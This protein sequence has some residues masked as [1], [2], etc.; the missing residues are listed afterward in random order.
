MHTYSLQFNCLF[1][2]F[3]NDH[4]NKTIY[5]G[6]TFTSSFHADAPLVW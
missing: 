1:I 3:L 4:M 6:F 5:S 2:Q